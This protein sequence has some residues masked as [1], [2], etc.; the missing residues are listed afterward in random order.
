[1]LA[2]TIILKNL[3]PKSLHKQ[4]IQLESIQREMIAED[5]ADAETVKKT[6]ALL[7]TIEEELRKQARMLHPH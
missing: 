7:H 3:D 1:M 2:N 5:N 6:V 4:I